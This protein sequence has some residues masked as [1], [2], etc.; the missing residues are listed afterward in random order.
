MGVSCSVWAPTPYITVRKLSL[1]GELEK[2]RPH[3]T[4]FSFFRDHDLVLPI[5]TARKQ[6]AYIFRLLM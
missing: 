3:L 5:A 4:I 6:L 2:M 1:D